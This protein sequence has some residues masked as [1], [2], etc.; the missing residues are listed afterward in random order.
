MSALALMVAWPAATNRSPWRRRATTA[1]LTF[2]PAPAMSRNS[3]CPPPGTS[4]AMATGVALSRS[5]IPTSS[6][7]R[8]NLSA[9]IRTRT[10]TCWP[11]TNDPP[12]PASTSSVVS[13][14][15]GPAHRTGAMTATA[16]AHQHP[17]CTGRDISPRGLS[18]TVSL[19]DV[20]R[21]GVWS[22]LVPAIFS[23]GGRRSPA[24]QRHEGPVTATAR[25]SQSGG[26]MV[27]RH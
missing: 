6:V 17:P 2:S 15:V 25:L 23:G 3:F 16:S 19:S 20:L 8:T 11:G 14:E 18:A 1:G 7:A 22:R 21:S 9:E 5:P 26:W 27:E 13:A 10:G 12:Y 4:T 24:E